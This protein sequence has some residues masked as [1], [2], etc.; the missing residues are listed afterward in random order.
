MTPGLGRSPGKG[1]GYPLQYSGLENSVDCKESTGR[2]ES[3]TMERLSLSLFRLSLSIEVGIQ[4]KMHL[5]YL[6]QTSGFQ[7]ASYNSLMS[8]FI[9]AGN[10]KHEGGRERMTDWGGWEEKKCKVTDSIK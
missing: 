9:L 2:K 4:N 5:P 1:K 8:L 3:D 7:T 10:N 6:F